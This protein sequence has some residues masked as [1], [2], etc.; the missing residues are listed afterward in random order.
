MYSDQPHGEAARE[1]L[2]EDD[3]D[4]LTSTEVSERLR[5]EVAAAESLVAELEAGGDVAAAGAARERVSALRAAVQRNARQP[6]NDEHFE[7]F[8]GYPPNRG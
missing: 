3:Q 8:F 4:L 5:L 7:K 6:M 2:D 1:K